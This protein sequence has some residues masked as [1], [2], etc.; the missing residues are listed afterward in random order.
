MHDISEK[1]MRVYAVILEQCGEFDK[2]G[3][4]L[5]LSELQR[6][7]TQQLVRNTHV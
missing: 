7:A 3:C 1:D 4:A 5:N 6:K 2:V